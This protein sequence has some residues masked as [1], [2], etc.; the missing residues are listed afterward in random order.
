[1]VISVKWVV[2]VKGN[3]LIPD[4]GT[5][6]GY[7]DPEGMGTGSNFHSESKVGVD[8]FIGRQ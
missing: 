7:K 3:S 2:C 1:M 5:V 8:L 4:D 6:V